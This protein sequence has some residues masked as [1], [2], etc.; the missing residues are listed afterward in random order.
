MSAAIQ[1]F[2]IQAMMSHYAISQGDWTTISAHWQSELSRDPMNLAVRRN[3]IQEQEAARLRAG[4]QPMNASVQRSAAGA[5]PAGGAAAFDPNAQMAA[6]MQAAQ[7]QQ[8][9]SMQ[10]AASMMGQGAVQGAAQLAGAMNALVGGSPLV[11]GR[12]VMVQWADGNKYP[13]TL[14]QN[15]G[16][17]AQVVFPNGQQMWVETRYLSPG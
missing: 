16:P 7:A 17:Q 14:L 15:T 5:A 4:G 11:V 2:G 12:Q 10:Y 9:A 13:A 1:V 6:Q 3:Q 8:A